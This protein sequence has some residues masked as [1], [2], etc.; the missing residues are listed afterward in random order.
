M[1]RQPRRPPPTRPSRRRRTRVT[2]PV[3]PRS[4]AARL[5]EAERLFRDFAVLTP[6]PFVPFA[7]TFDSFEDYRRWR[8]A[9]TNPW[10]R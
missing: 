3:T 1:L 2:E 5:R 4:A 9:Q 6:Y 10:Y 7:R 8:D